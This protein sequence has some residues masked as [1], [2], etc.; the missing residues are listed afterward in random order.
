MS[1]GDRM[2]S[3]AFYLIFP[4]IHKPHGNI[5][6]ARYIRVFLFFFSELD[7]SSSI[8]FHFC[9]DEPRCCVLDSVCAYWLV[10]V[11]V[12]DASSQMQ[13]RLIYTILSVACFFFFS[14]VWLSA[15]LRPSS[16][17]FALL[18]RLYSIS[19]NKG[20]EEDWRN[21]IFIYLSIYK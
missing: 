11:C 2:K 8:N 13:P 1:G 18:S 12:W 14:V 17:T 20:E 9:L 4:S 10:C 7:Y 21:A 6:N 3:Y 16:L 5:K 19:I 15:L